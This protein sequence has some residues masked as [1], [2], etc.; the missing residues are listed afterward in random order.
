M[1]DEEGEGS[2]SFVH[3]CFS[4]KAAYVFQADVDQIKLI[5]SL[6]TKSKRNFWAISSEVAIRQAVALHWENINHMDI[7]RWMMGCGC[8]FS[9]RMGIWQRR[10]LDMH[11]HFV[12][13]NEI[14]V[15]FKWRWK[16]YH[17]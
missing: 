16:I 13:R 11:D 1:N 4:Y 3:M 9:V 6:L 14:L 2:S 7:S 5:R 15:L 12:S 8:I 17:F 10:L